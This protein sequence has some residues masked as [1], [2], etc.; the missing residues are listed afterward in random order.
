MYGE[1]GL[2]DTTAI[3]KTRLIRHGYICLNDLLHKDISQMAKDIKIS[4]VQINDLL[5]QADFYSQNISGFLRYQSVNNEKL[6]SLNKSIDCVTGNGFRLGGVHEIVGLS[7]CGKT[8]LVI[9]YAVTVQIPKELGGIGGK[10]LYIDTDGTLSIL[11]LKQIIN[12]YT[13]YFRS[14]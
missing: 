14:N 1:I 9:Q 7:G 5:K 12:G 2:L 8:N 4:E 13:A 11:R 10:A 6:V 3:I